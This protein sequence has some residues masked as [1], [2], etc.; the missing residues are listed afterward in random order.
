MG[1]Q[2]SKFWRN[3]QQT[4]VNV[5]RFFSSAKLSKSL[6]N[7]MF[8]TRFKG[9]N[10]IIATSFEC[11]HIKIYRFIKPLKAFFGDQ[12][13]CLFH[14]PGVLLFPKRLFDY[15]RSLNREKT[16]QIQK[17]ISYFLGTVSWWTLVLVS[18]KLEL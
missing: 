3:T 13:R 12:E 5:F 14:G 16:K 1:P 6:K 17:N 4:G 8:C 10:Q 9:N 7:R 18:C 11:K 15:E 2:N